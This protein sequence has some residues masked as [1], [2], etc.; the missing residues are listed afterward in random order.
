MPILIVLIVLIVVYCHL[1]L[2]RVMIS[3]PAP[4]DREPREPCRVL[5]PR[6]SHGCEGVTRNRAARNTSKDHSAAVSS[7]SSQ[8]LSTRCPFLICLTVVLGYAL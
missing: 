5:P 6:Y 1:L 7:S 8:A 2:V 4:A 3:A